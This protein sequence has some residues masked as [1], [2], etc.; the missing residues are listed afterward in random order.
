VALASEKNILSKSTFIRGVQCLKSLYL[1]K[2]R[3]FLRD[4]LSPEQ[5][6]KFSRG[7]SV[8]LLA[9]QLFPGGIN[10][11]P[12][13]PAQSAKSVNKT[14]E[15][16]ESRAS[17]I[18]EAAF[19]YNQLII[20]LDILVRTETGWHA[21]EVKSSLSVSE[22][23]IQDA[24]LQYHVIEGSGIHLESFSIIYLNADYSLESSLD[25]SQYFLRKEVTQ[26]LINKQEWI[27]NQIIAS[28][29]AL[30]L[31]KSPPISVSS[32]CYQP[33]PCDFRGHCWKNLNYPVFE[34]PGFSL[35]R[36]LEFID[37]GI[38]ALADIPYPELSENEKKVIDAHKSG[39]EFFDKE[40]VRSFLGT[41]SLPDFYI[42]FTL[43]RMAL[44]VFEGMKPYEPLIVGFTLIMSTGE[45]MSVITPPGSY[46]GNYIPEILLKIKAEGHK[47]FY[48]GEDIVDQALEKGLPG[49]ADSDFL[50]NI[51][52]VFSG[53][54]YYN[55]AQTSI[56]NVNLIAES[57]GLIQTRTGVIS[58]VMTGVN[59][60][61]A[62]P[63]IQVHD[64]EAIKK[65]AATGAESLKLIVE[66]LMQKIRN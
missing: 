55:P 65:S 50:T 5:L 11:A 3:P 51:S 6:A 29:E 12:S 42:K 36:K 37:R 28:K 60:L 4:R 56:D 27:E 63:G 59:Y 13:H 54:H 40:K 16:I 10:C 24:A 31:K 64:F 21:F 61:K 58:D 57:I 53:F 38:V 20:F 9:Q 39:S 62:D 15:L 52:G 44:P 18:Y 46:P 19:S 30:E 7:H 49:N 32:R 34:I 45:T 25:I 41:D 8:G 26:A 1:N 23:Y 14:A 17:V 66:H 2:H 33:Y 35:H 48:F 22:T 43:V 47:G